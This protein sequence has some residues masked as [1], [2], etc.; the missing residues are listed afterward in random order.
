MPGNKENY[1]LLIVHAIPVNVRQTV[2][3][4][5]YS[6]P[7]Y[8]EGNLYAYQHA[9]AP[10]SAG[11]RE[12]PFDAVIL[13]YSFLNYRTT[14]LYQQLREKYEFIKNSPACKIAISQ[15]EFNCNEILD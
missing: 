7:A 1:K 8:G 3:D 5:L 11:L 4:H 10:I 2:I 15:D 9:L 12:F 14:E 6:F 13:D